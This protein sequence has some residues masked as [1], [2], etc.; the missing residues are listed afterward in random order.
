MSYLV[1]LLE[2]M[3]VLSNLHGEGT[4]ICDFVMVVKIYKSYIYMMYSNP[5]SN[6]QHEHFEMFSDTVEN[7]FATIT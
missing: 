6:Y 4:F 5:S 3:N 1:P 7:N 2:T